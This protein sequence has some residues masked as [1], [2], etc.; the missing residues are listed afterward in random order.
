MPLEKSP[1]KLCARK[2]LLV[3]AI[4]IAIDF[5]ISS[6]VVVEAAGNCFWRSV[7]TPKPHGGN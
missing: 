6:F 5:L 3:V 2:L 7:A 4:A 1:R